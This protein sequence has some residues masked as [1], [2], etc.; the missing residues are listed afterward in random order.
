MGQERR[1]LVKECEEC[2]GGGGE[3]LRGGG[4]PS[5]NGVGH[6]LPDGQCKGEVAPTDGGR[7]QAATTLKFVVHT[8]MGNMTGFCPNPAFFEQGGGGALCY[9]VPARSTP[10]P[11]GGRSVLQPGVCP[12]SPSLV[13][14]P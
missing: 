6:P 10:P 9:G 12:S 14:V 13:S 5:Q 11:P 1:V 7:E 3:V 2:E 4:Q 8:H